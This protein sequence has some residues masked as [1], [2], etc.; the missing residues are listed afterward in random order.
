MCF[1]VLGAYQEIALIFFTEAE[2]NSHLDLSKLPSPWELRFIAQ[3]R[4]YSGDVR[5][6]AQ[7]RVFRQFWLTHGHTIMCYR[8]PVNNQLH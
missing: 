7:V 1:A 2:G 8:H 4:V 6:A 3:E 5:A